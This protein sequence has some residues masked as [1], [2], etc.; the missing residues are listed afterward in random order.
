MWPAW[1]ARFDEIIIPPKCIPFSQ[2]MQLN[3]WNMQTADFLF[4]QMCNITIH[5]KKTN[6]KWNSFLKYGWSNADHMVLVLVAKLVD[7]CVI[8]IG[9]ESI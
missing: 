4:F 1:P 8:C 2:K 6:D 5:G 9:A 7:I 3:Y